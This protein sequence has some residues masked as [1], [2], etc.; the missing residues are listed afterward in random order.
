MLSLKFKRNLLLSLFGLALL[1][2][3]ISIVFKNYLFAPY[4]Y[5]NNMDTEEIRERFRSIINDFGIEDKLIKETKSKDK[6]SGQDIPNIKVQV[7]KD[8]SIPEILQDIF[9]SFGKDSLLIHSVEKVKGGKSTLVLKKGNSAILQSEFDY[10]KNYTRNKG[11]IAFV[12]KDP[13]LESPSTNVLVESSTKVNLLIRPNT[14]YIQHLDFIQKNRK[15][16][17]LLIDDE[18]DE[19]K[20]KLG[21]SYS[22]QRVVTVIKTLVKDF[23][24]AVCFIVDDNSKFYSSAN[25]EILSR[26]LAKRKIK[27][28]RLSEFV[29]LED[30]EK[31]I[32]IF[33]GQMENLGG[34]KEII[35]LLTK[36]T[37][38]AINPEIK[39]YKK[40]GYRIVNSSLMFGNA[41]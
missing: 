35:F 30:D 6:F 34:N 26:E 4:S 41:E 1:L 15:E 25:Q 21:A 23:S 5:E 10:A 3:V 2:I 18:I 27:L 29:I 19:Q 36:E 33:E 8:L 11:F 40:R 22:E 7:P 9:Q 28:F 24:K 20:Y 38:L 37:Y 12:I 31:L 39:K 32:S 17:S 13:D 16:F 14:K